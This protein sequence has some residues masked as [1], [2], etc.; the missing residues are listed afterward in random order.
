MIN[1]LV[2]ALIAAHNGANIPLGFGERAT[3]IGLAG[4]NVLEA[5]QVKA[6]NPRVIKRLYKLQR[7]TKDGIR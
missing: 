3:V 4:R 2:D 6:I 1:T 5:V 7:V